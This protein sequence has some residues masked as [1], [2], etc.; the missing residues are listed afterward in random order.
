MMREQQLV[1]ALGQNYHSTT[2]SNQPHKFG[3][4]V[5]EK[6]SQPPDPIKCFICVHENML[7]ASFVSSIVYMR[8][9]KCLGI[10]VTLMLECRDVNNPK[11]T[12]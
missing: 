9:K 7:H 6:F 5:V 12:V 1:Q 8:K 4:G 3:G 10:M 11:R 2:R